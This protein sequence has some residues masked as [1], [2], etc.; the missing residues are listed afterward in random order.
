MK[1]FL[2]V[3]FLILVINIISPSTTQAQFLKKLK[4]RAIEAAEEAAIMKT[5][6]KVAQKTGQAIDKAFSM[7]FSKMF[8]NRSGNSKASSADLPESYD[9]EWKYSMQMQTKEGEFNMDYYLKPDAKYFGV[10]PEIKQSKNQGNMFMVMDIERKI[11]T[12]FMDMESSKMASPMAIPD[13]MA[14]EGEIENQNNEYT[15]KEI[16]SKEILGYKCLGFKMENNEAVMVFYATMDAPVSFSQVYG[17][18]KKNVPRGFDPKWLDKV[19]NGLVM[20]MNYTDK[21]K[22][23]NSARM[24]C[25]ALNEEIFSIH[26]DD[27][28]FMDM[29]M[30]NE[31][32]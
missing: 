32:E 17:F 21:K 16:D 9:F 10:K 25:V 20:E 6:E 12:V 26:K 8:S 13:E 2:N 15:F 29:N 4:N 5:E 30:S 7:D 14:K 27:Y 1:P 24:T 19:G 31:K 22:E 28:Q 18:D 3:F 11:N 23:K